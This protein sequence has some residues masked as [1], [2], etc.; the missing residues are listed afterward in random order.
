MRSSDWSSDV[1]SSDLRAALPS[2]RR[3]GTL[4]RNGSRS[5]ELQ[6]L[7]QI[8]QK[9]SSR[10]IIPRGPQQAASA[11]RAFEV[12]FYVTRER[13]SVVKGKIVS[14]REYLGWHTII[15]KTKKKH[16]SN[17]TPRL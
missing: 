2:R 6:A 16:N 10:S 5:L 3:T 9:P 15:K 4:G 14:T 13:K 11:N 12:N 7:L 8:L 17:H 1:F